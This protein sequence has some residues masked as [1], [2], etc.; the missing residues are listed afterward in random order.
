MSRR[1]GTVVFGVVAALVVVLV[2][3]HGAHADDG[4]QARDLL[5]RAQGAASDHEFEATV[6]I[7]WLEGGRRQERTVSVKVH[8]GVLRVGDDR[9]VSAGTRRMLRTD[10]GWRL[11]WAGT[12]SGSEPDPT[13]K[14][15][16]AVTSDASVAQRAATQVEVAREGSRRVRERLYFDDAT[17][18]LLRRDELDAR[19]R[20]V[21]RFAF[22]KMSTPR[23]VSSS[24]VRLPKVDA[25]SRATAPHAL[26]DV[27]DDLH[28]PKRIGRGFTLSGVYSQAD[29]SVQLFY[30]DGLLGV[31][32]FE[33]E[34]ELAWNDLPEGGR[35]VELGDVRARVY[36]TAAGT[37]AVWGNDGVTYT[38]VTDAP[39]DEVRA[40]AQD[41]SRSDDSGVLGEVG[42]FVTA[43]F[44]WG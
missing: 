43:P 11:L 42:R 24:E 15:R 36:A 23:P 16:F 18:M 10:D 31:S 22:V 4:G 21:R 38:C 13:D 35:A 1:R 32:V 14:Y 7:Q 41:L 37:A 40:I 3:A 26:K 28:A 30:S 33:R 19:G 20:L 2:G 39:I 29:G 12:S 8:D 34:G 17:G 5:D 44:N 27:P 6:A 9:L 25:Q